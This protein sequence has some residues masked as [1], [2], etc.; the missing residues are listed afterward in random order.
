VSKSKI[1][2]VRVDEKLAEDLERFAEVDG[3]AVAEQM[4][5]AIELLLESRRR[6]PEFHERVR[7]AV[8]RTQRL[9][10]EIGEPEVAGAL[11]VRKP[12]TATGRFRAQSEESP[13]LRA[14]RE[15]H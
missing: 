1:Y 3:V 5:R 12:A 11:I 7:K 6:D 10:A 15:R 13:R 2:S 4:R 14:A 9:L 8:E